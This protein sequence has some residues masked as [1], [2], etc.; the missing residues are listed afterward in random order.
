MHSRNQAT[1]AS[2]PVLPVVVSLNPLQSVGF[3]L[4]C[5]YLFLLF[6][7]L[8]DYVY[9]LHLPAVLMTVLALLL[10]ASG[11]LQR[12]LRRRIVHWMAA[13]TVFFGL[14]IPLSVWP[15]GATE[16]FTSTWIK[17]AVAFVVVFGLAT[18]GQQIRTACMWIALGALVSAVMNSTV[19]YGR[20]SAGAGQRFGDANEFAQLLLVGMFLLGA[21]MVRRNT[22]LLPRALAAVGIVFELVTFLRTGS[23]GGLVGLLVVLLFFFFKGTPRARLVLVSLALIVTL[24][25]IALL[26]ATVKNRYAMLFGLDTPSITEEEIAAAGSAES[27]QYLLLQSLK[28]TAQNPL[29][30][31][32]LGM[33]AVAEN[34]EARQK[35]LPRGIWHETHNMYTQV[36]SEAGI[37]ALI[38]FVAVLWCAFK[39]VKEAQRPSRITDPLAGDLQGL[40]KWL[41]LSLIGLASSG[42]FLSVAYTQELH[43]LLALAAGLGSAVVARSGFQVPAIPRPLPRPSPTRP[44]IK[45]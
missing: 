19:Q 32:G 11:G 1:I 17:T 28:I 16:T 35:G 27:R 21:Y 43:I 7:R 6:S 41:Q 4:L 36:S 42:F 34:D 45:V 15:G 8:H 18:T 9:Y 12:V 13:L 44:V 30:G 22:P 37:P 33:F 5:V 25:A 26:P 31:A 2:T 3:F 38:C 20:L 24:L 23:R 39:A 29:L 40:A 10:V 14:S